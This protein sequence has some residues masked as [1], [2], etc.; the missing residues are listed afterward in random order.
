MQFQ[1]LFLSVKN[2]HEMAAYPGFVVID[3]GW[4]VRFGTLIFSLLFT[5]LLFCSISICSAGVM[6]GSQFIL[7]NVEVPV[8]VKTY[9]NGEYK[10]EPS[11]W[12]S[13]SAATT[14]PNV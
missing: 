12:L 9:K 13:L 6:D 1:K 4:E 7:A 11:P 3:L 2:S 14:F 10:D 8:T 5:K